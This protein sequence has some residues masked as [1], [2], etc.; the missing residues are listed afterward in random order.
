M[1][2]S[3]IKN[4]EDVQL[5]VDTFYGKIREDK[6]LGSIFNGVI[7]DRW[8]QHLEKMYGFWQT[9]LLGEHT[10]FGRP[11]P[12]HI[13]LPIDESHFEQWLVHFFTTVDD[14][15]EGEKAEE[16]K[17]RAHKMAE[18]FSYKHAY[19]RQNQGNAIQ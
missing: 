5:M 17:T 6:S 15:F 4:L 9:I 16:A 19:F 12:P 8:P 13:P 3:D 14:L 18:M 7:Q 2:K 1:P 10:Y 11:F